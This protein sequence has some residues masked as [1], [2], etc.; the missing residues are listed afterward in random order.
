MRRVAD[1]QA[2]LRQFPW[3][4]LEK[5]GGFA[6][7]IALARFGVL[8][9]DMGFWSHKVGP[10]P[11][12][13]QGR[14][15]MT[16]TGYG[17]SHAKFF[18]KFDHLDG[19]DLLKNKHLTDEEGWKL[20]SNLIPYRVFDG[21]RTEKRP[22]LVTDFGELVKDWDSWY[23][24]RKI[25]KES[26]AALLMSFPL[27]VYHLIVN[28]LQVSNPM[29][30]RP[31]TRVPLHIHM[32]GVE[33][34]LNY[35]PLCAYTNPLSSFPVINTFI[36]RF[37]E[38]AL[39]LPYHDIKLVMFGPCVHDLSNEALKNP[40][41]ESLIGQSS[42]HSPIFYY[43]AP[44]E[45]GSGTLSVLLHTQ[46]SIW[47]PHEQLSTD[48]PFL[49][50]GPPDA[51]VACNAGLASYPEWSLVL[52]ASHLFNIP[53]A[54]TEYAE[55]SAETQSSN[56][57]KLLGMYVQ[58]RPEYPIELNPFHC[59]GQRPI[60]VYRVPNLSN[61][62]TLVVVKKEE[63]DADVEINL[64]ASPDTNSHAP[65][66]SESPTRDVMAYLSFWKLSAAAMLTAVFFALYKVR[67]LEK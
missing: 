23:R 53:F 19:K 2:I 36:N 33:L 12:Q 8:G 59:P 10:V 54:T 63:K 46:S 32:L 50:D 47:D 52:Q 58:A 25:P 6:K 30:G 5:D 61:G 22:V 37:S 11:H 35:L 9:N 27:T 41:P 16:S 20:P 45:C 28:C 18:A 4:R 44:E 39:L 60:P 34:E 7:D 13:K 29:R 67:N 24:W 38:L 3:G 57:Q 56:M 43:T 65:G 26:P 31:E 64:K 66:F 21:P 55:Q 42:A 48:T 15:V 40:S 1:A 62:F 51:L 17:P 14:S 49:Y